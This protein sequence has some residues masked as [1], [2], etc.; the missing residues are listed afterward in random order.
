MLV[1]VTK[2]TETYLE[3]Q[4]REYCEKMEP[5]LR[6]ALRQ[7][8]QQEEDLRGQRRLL[9]RLLRAKFGDLPTDV[10]VQLE[11]IPTAEELDELSERLLSAATLEDLRLGRDGQK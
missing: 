7:E 4:F 10:P 1:D 5:V 6:E 8:I 3:R 9:L 2:I 11:A